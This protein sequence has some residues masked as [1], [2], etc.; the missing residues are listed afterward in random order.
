V[1]MAAVFGLRLHGLTGSVA[2]VLALTV[3]PVALM[4][5]VGMLYARY[6][7]APGISGGLAGLAAGVAG[8]M[9]ATAARMAEPLVRSRFGHEPLI[10]VAAFVAIGIFRLPLLP[11]LAVLAPASIALA[12]WVRR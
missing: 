8:L 3:P 2:A 12:W 11:V 1:N 4:I 9:I 10:A 7:G 6:G 5:A